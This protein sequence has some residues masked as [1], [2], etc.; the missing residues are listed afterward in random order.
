M[1]A[2]SK[3]VLDAI[4]LISHS[5][6]GNEM[7]VSQFCEDV[8]TPLSEGRVIFYYAEKDNGV[9]YPAAFLTWCWLSG[10]RSELFGKGEYSP[11]LEDYRQ[12][13]GDKM[14]GVWYVAPFGHFRQLWRE[15]TDRCRKRY[16]PTKVHWTRNSRDK[17]I[18]TYRGKM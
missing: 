9:V 1:T 11:V 5:D 7:S 8:L 12:T 3:E 18:R 4:Y 15:A 6:V 2:S 17:T 13:I 14:W 16:G 10:E